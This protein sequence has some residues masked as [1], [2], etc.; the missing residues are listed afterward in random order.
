[1]LEI[2]SLEYQK[3]STV[4]KTMQVSETWTKIEKNLP[5]R[6]QELGQSSLLIDWPGSFEQMTWRLT[7]CGFGLVS[8]R[9]GL[10]DSINPNATSV[11]LKNFHNESFE[12]HYFYIK[13][14]L[15]IEIQVTMKF[16]PLI[17]TKA[18]IYVFTFLFF[19]VWGWK[20]QSKIA[21]QNLNSRATFPAY[22]H[23][24]PKVSDARG[25]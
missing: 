21:S 1:M 24:E 7:G 2:P 16:L 4:L 19:F 17:Q 14:S 23:H 12:E 11:H 20:G 13:A 9:I 5:T 3:Q 10:Q 6:S 25:R 22:D 8:A 15:Y 18:E